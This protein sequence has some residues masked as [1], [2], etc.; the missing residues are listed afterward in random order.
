MVSPEYIPSPFE[1]NEKCGVIG[2]FSP[3][4]K[5][6]PITF[7][8]LSSVQHRGQE[9]CGIAS[10]DGKSLTEHKGNGLV[11]E[12]FDRGFDFENLPGEISIGHTR[13]A[14]SSIDTKPGAHIQPVTSKYGNLA[15]AHNGNLPDTSTLEQYF[16]EHNIPNPGYNDTEL[17]HRDIEYQLQ[18]GVSIE[19]AV[20]KSSK[21]FT[22]AWSLTMMTPDKLIAARDPKGIRPLSIGKLNGGY[23]VSSETC[24]FD[25]VD[26][27]FIRDILP[28]E[29][30]VIDKNGMKSTELAKGEQKLDIFE[31][32][33]FARPDSYLLGQNVALV[34]ERMGQILAR[35]ME[36]DGK[37]DADIVLGVP[38]SGTRAGYGFAE[39]SG[40]KHKDGFVRDRY[41]GRTF[42][43]PEQFSREAGVN[44]KLNPLREMVRDQKIIVLDDSIVRGTTAKR[45]VK[46]L[47]DSGAREVHLAITCPPIRYPDFYGID[48]PQ[49]SELFSVKNPTI[50]K[51]ADALSVDSLHFLSLEGMIEATGISRELFSTSAFTGE[52]PVDIGVKRTQI[53]KLESI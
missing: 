39:A 35:E 42:Q 41:A 19:E 46:K 26:A 9:S 15:L 12:V 22:G 51:M 29:M 21:R 48:T 40:I 32:I 24:T 5:S 38:D 53:K 33:Y 8:G 34:R 6:A 18:K 11:L 28:G 20:V 37:L 43:K 16:D 14:T 47:R 49:Q 7:V 44:K 45:V 30:I 17:M 3:Q 36:K 52:Y 10:S 2:T 50:R 27:Q 31:F 4:H 1:L 13:Y 25:L 23:I